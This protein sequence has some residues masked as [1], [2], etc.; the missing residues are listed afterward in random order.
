M[1][2]FSCIGK[3]LRGDHNQVLPPP[4]DIVLRHREQ[5]MFQNPNTGIFQL[6]KELRNV[7]YH[8]WK[9]CIGPHFSDFHPAVHIKVESSVECLLSSE[10]LSLLQREFNI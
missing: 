10:H 6:S 2:Q 3:I 8:P 4:D 9:T 7:Y 5:V 1:N